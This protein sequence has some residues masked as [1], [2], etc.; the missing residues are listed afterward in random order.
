MESEE[1]EKPCAIGEKRKLSVAQ[2]TGSDG[3][4]DSSLKKM[5]LSEPSSSRL[6]VIVHPV[7]VTAT[8]AAPQHS[9]ANL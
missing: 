1:P 2:P 4:L 7:V 9:F 5:R 3:G 6:Q 8:E